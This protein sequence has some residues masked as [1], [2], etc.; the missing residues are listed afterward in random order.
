MGG[1]LDLVQSLGLSGFIKRVQSQLHNEAEPIPQI[2]DTPLDEESQF[3][4][5]LHDCRC[6]RWR[7]GRVILLGDAAT[8]FLPTAG[9]GASMAMESAA[10]L[11]D[12]LSRTNAERVEQ[13]LD[14]Y[15]K[16][17]RQRVEKAQNES[18]KLARL[19]FIQSKPVDWF[20]KQ[21]FK[22]YSVENLVNSMVRLMEEPV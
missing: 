16:R 11:S 10:V 15:E 3:F 2:L 21:L 14:L 4:W 7:Q 17:H 13:A 12:E 5:S 19:M 22:F 8:G 9:L 6:Y 1:P 18:R 20:R